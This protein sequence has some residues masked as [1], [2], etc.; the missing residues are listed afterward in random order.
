MVLQV[1][2]IL[3]ETDACNQFPGNAVRFNMEAD[4]LNCSILRLDAK[5]EL[6]NLICSSKKL[7][8]K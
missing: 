8:M 7:K 3:V 1:L 6:Q 4:S 5:P 2:Q